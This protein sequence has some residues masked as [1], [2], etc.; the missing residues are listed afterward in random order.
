[1]DAFP[2]FTRLSIDA[3]IADRH[4]IYNVDYP[5]FEYAAHLEEARQVFLVEVHELLE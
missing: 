4:G 3:I 2:S 5:A 1:V